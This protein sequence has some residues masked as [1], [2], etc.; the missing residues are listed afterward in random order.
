MPDQDVI[1]RYVTE[2][3]KLKTLNQWRAQGKQGARP[4]GSP[5][6]GMMNMCKRELERRGVT[7]PH[8]DPPAEQH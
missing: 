4:C 2:T 5:N 1:R 3:R 6:L 8:V 7:V